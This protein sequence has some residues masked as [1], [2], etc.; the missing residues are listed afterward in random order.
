MQA[1]NL[2]EGG[3]YLAKVSGKITT[4]RITRVRLRGDRV[5]YDVI[6]VPTGRK[7]TFRSPQRFL[8]VRVT[9]MARDPQKAGPRTY[10]GLERLFSL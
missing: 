9:V 1:K 6:N 8:R 4:V 2:V 5:V 3:Y 7:I 10:H